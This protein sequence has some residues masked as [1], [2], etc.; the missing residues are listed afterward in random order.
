[1]RQVTITR[2]STDLQL[3]TQGV[4]MIDSL[5]V[6]V[7]LEDYKYGNIRNMSCIPTGQYLCKR[8]SSSKF[9]NTF[10]VVSVPERSGI[11]FH[12]GN[13]TND[14]EGCVLLGSEF[15]YDDNK[16]TIKESTKAF[17]K[18]IDLLEDE[19]EFRLTIREAF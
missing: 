16:I 12:I 17:N 9:P 2:V 7:T 10:K 4:L 15:N 3:G 1:M 14:T 5:P 19:K 6:C 8:Y 18:F 13:N 11:L